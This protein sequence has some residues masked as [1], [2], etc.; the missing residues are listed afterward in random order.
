V[1]RTYISSRDG[2]TAVFA[3]KHKTT[4]EDTDKIRI[5]L[6]C[7]PVPGEELSYVDLTELLQPLSE[8]SDLFRCHCI[9]SD[10]EK[11]TIVNDNAYTFF[12]T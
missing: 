4:T 8:L 5:L 10:D 3:P 1:Y 2:N 11:G 7:G 6:P 9:F 12:K